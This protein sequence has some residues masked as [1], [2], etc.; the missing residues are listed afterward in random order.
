MR[1]R[2]FDHMVNEISVEVGRQVP[3]FALWTALRDAGMDPESL[4]REGVLAFFDGHLRGFLRAHGMALAAR[5]ARRVRRRI[6]RYDPA[7]PSPE[8]VFA[9]F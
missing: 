3:R 8:E 4:S 5:G 9:R 2:R 1:R 6:A 7:W